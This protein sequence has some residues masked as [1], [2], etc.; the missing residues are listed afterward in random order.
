MT[1]DYEL[2]VILSPRLNADEATALNETILGLVRD[3]GGE[4]I[5]TDPW[6]RRMLAYPI[7]KVQEAYY[8]VNYFKLDSLAVKPLKRLFNINENIMRHMFVLRDEK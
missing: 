4:I 1:K 6:G 2:M 5:K 7:E 8:Y 3:N